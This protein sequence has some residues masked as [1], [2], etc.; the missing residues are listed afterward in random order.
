VESGLQALQNEL[1][2]ER[3]ALEGADF[4]LANEHA[5]LSQTLGGPG[6]SHHA[7]GAQRLAE[8]QQQRLQLRIDWRERMQRRLDVAQQELRTLQRI[9]RFRDATMEAELARKIAL[10]EHEVNS[11]SF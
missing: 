3:S 9:E 2:E 10:L 5:F 7:A 1:R 8:V 11:P 4:Q 6:S